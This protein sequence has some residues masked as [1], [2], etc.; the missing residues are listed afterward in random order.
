MREALDSMED[1][2]TMRLPAFMAERRLE[3]A[4]Q[5][6]LFWEKQAFSWEEKLVAPL[7]AAPNGETR[8]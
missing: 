7:I 2:V 1:M 5:A 3:D 8:K 6:F 4:L